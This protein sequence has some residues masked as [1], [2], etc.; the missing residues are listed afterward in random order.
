LHHWSERVAAITASGLDEEA[1]I[2]KFSEEV[3]ADAAKYLKPA[4]LAEYSF[5]AAL[6]LSWAGL[7]RYHRKR[8]EAASASH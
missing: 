5:A 6:N 4:E 1:C 8:A 2:R 3:A 7:A